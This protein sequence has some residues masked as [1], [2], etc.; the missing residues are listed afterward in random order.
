MKIAPSCN[1]CSE[2]GAT[3]RPD[4]RETLCD[5]CAEAVRADAEYDRVQGIIRQWDWFWKQG[6]KSVLYA[7]EHTRSATGCK[8][9]EL[10]AIIAPVCRDRAFRASRELVRMAKLKAPMSMEEA[11]MI[12]H[13]SNTMNR[14]AELLE[15]ILKELS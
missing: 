2:G 14:A 11:G 7:I 15:R 13:R 8:A 9:V 12:Q 4:L 3:F 5:G 10:A 6:Q 1:R